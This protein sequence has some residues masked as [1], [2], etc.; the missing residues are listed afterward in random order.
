MRGIS[1]AQLYAEKQEELDLEMIVEAPDARLPIT[2]SEVNRPGLALAGFTQNFLYERIQILGET[3]TLYL[4]TL[5]AAQRKKP[6]SPPVPEM[7]SPS[8]PTSRYCM[9]WFSPSPMI[10]EPSVA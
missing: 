5:S 7:T 2:V 3:E 9:P 6:S 8:E 4:D 10:S 1:A